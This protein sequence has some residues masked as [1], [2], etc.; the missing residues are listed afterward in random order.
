MELKKLLVRERFLGYKDVI[1]LRKFRANLK[2]TKSRKKRKRI[3]LNI[4][5]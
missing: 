5:N 1:K 4:I 2:R 3:V